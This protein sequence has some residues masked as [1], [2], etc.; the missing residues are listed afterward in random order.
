MPKH[1]LCFYKKLMSVNL[2]EIKLQVKGWR[3]RKVWGFVL[4]NNNKKMTGWEGKAA[5][6]YQ[7]PNEMSLLLLGGECR[8]EKLSKWS[9]E[10]LI[11]RFTSEH[12]LFFY[13]V[14]L[15]SCPPHPSSLPLLNRGQSNLN[16][17]NYNYIASLNNKIIPLIQITDNFSVLNANVG[18]VLGLRK[19]LILKYS[20]LT[21][22]SHLKIHFL[23]ILKET[24]V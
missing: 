14:L 5:V 4:K 6:F 20:V 11:T 2:S 3:E 1:Y 7:R 18:W 12:P 19:Q 8:R 15:G 9:H 22:K 16:P 17:A 24:Y 13:L 10:I 23:N 21:E